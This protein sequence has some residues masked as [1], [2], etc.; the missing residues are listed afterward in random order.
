[1]RIEG[2]IVKAGE[3]RGISSVSLSD[4]RRLPFSSRLDQAL[5][6]LCKDLAIPL[7]IWLQKNSREFAPYHQTVF[8]AEQFAEKVRFDYFY[9]RLIDD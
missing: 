5:L 2:T 9:L 3:V 8:P 6:Q 7:P 1:M 4:D